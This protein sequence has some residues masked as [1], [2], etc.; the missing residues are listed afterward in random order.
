MEVRKSAPEVRE[1]ESVCVAVSG[2][3][4]DGVRGEREERNAGAGK[5]ERKVGREWRSKS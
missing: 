3:V 4:R 1:S 5:I 2:R